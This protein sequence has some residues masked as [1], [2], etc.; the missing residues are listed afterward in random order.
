MATKTNFLAAVQRKS[1]SLAEATRPGETIKLDDGDLAREK[2]PPVPVALENQITHGTQ[3][4][5]R[6]VSDTAPRR[7][8]T[9]YIEEAN[10]MRLK[11]LGLK[12]RRKLNHYLSE[13]VD[14]YLNKIADKLDAL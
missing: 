10:Y 12:E 9:V 7:G 1:L 14:D 3:H 11:I 13:A 6:P 8:T 4:K 5:S 2:V